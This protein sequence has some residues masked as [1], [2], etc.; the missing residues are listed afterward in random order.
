ML[1][2][3]EIGLD[4]IPLFNLLASTI[5]KTLVSALIQHRGEDFITLFGYRLRTFQHEG[6]LFLPLW[7]HNETFSSGNQ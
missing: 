7:V 3:I 5:G 2:P 6:T 1:S 4:R